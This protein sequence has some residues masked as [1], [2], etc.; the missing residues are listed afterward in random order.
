MKMWWSVIGVCVVLGVGCGKKATP[1][2]EEVSAPAD[3]A[4]AAKDAAE[5]PK[6]TAAPDTAA[7]APD[8]AAAT[9]D[10]AA[11]PAGDAS[12]PAG[13]T[14]PAGGDAAAPD[15]AAANDAAPTGD[16]A[17]ADAT[18]TGA[19]DAAPA[20]DAAVMIGDVAVASLP[21][22]VAPPKPWDELDEKE[23]KAHMKENVMPVMRARFQAFDGE[24][25]AKFTC[26][27]CHGK[28]AKE[29]K[30][31][32]PNA[33]LPKLPNNREDFGKLMEKEPEGCKFMMDVVNPDMAKLLGEAPFDPATGKGFGCGG[34]HVIPGFNDKPHDDHGGHDH[35]EGHDHK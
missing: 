30:F 3:T 25:F 5:A 14:A 34:C 32:M 4:E 20:E 10:A 33:E 8:A 11:A 27:T 19:A 35:H 12:A 13:D 1:A 26:G 22:P 7:A 9:P 17:A 15:A 23:Q 6:D 16:V 29:G 24:E 2:P 21:V 18:K 28:G 31:E